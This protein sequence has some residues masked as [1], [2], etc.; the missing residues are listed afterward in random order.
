MAGIL[1]ECC[2]DRIT[3]RCASASGTATVSRGPIR[4][5]MLGPER[6][7]VRAREIARASANVTFS[8]DRLLLER[9]ERDSRARHASHRV[10]ADAY[11]AHESLPG[12]AAWFYDNFHIVSETL[13]EIRT[14]LPFGY[15]RRLPKLRDGLFAG[16][17]RVYWLALE[18]VAHTDSAL[19]EGTLARF[20]QNYQEVTPLAIGE[21]WAVPIMLRLVLVENLCRLADGTVE[22]RNL[23]MLAKAW[24]ERLRKDETVPNQLAQDLVDNAGHLIV[25][26]LQG[27]RTDGVTRERLEQFEESCARRG[28]HV[29]DLLLGERQRQAANQ[30]TVGNGVTS[31]RLLSSI[32]WPVFYE[33][34]SLVDARLRT[35]PA[36]VYAG[37][38]FATR[39]RYRQAIEILVRD[40][41]KNELEICDRVSTGPNERPA[42]GADAPPASHVGYYLIG[43]GRSTFARGVCDKKVRD[44]SVLGPLPHSTGWYFGSIAS[45]VGLLLLATAGYASSR[46]AGWA[47][48][49]LPYCYCVRAAAEIAIGVVNFSLPRLF[50]RK[51]FRKWISPGNPARLLDFRRDANFVVERGGECFPARTN[52]NSLP[53]E[54]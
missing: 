45:L 2:H 12:E 17:P 47:M 15:Y 30:V 29:E 40:C 32:E 50:R 20:I 54:S 1:H 49:A 25:S 46:G 36:G 14:D 22:I 26:V 38:D 16:L 24:V 23:R 18:L 35:D 6:L 34:A 8:E 48:L 33:K 31:L 52:R 11:V 7:E 28:V 9:F 43:D 39:D 10:I 37:Q 3:S 19:E 41:G 27:L 5:E 44:W 13:R 51:R 21:L 42:S 53:I 4:G